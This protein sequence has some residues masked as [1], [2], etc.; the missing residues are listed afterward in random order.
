MKNLKTIGLVI[1][2]MKKP[3]NLLRTIITNLLS[4]EILEKTQCQF[5]AG[6]FSFVVRQIRRI[7]IL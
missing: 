7:D 2:L 3:L 1:G 6:S 4:S 5:D